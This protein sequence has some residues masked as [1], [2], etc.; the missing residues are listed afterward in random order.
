MPTDWQPKRAFQGWRYFEAK[1]VPA[2]L[3][4]GRGGY[5]LPPALRAELAELGLR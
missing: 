4:A 1:D 5:D 3:R 2:D